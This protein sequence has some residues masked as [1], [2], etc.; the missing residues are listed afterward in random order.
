MTSHYPK[1]RMPHSPSKRDGEQ[2][3]TAFRVR[4]DGAEDRV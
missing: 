1:V 4:S 3:L 2:Q